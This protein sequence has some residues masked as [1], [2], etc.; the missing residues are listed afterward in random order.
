VTS[1]AAELV[2][3]TVV[4]AMAT[5]GRFVVLRRWVFR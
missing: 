3:V 1:V 5:A 2:A 4:N